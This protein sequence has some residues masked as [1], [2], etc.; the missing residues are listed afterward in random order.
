MAEL[1]KAKLE[2][3]IYG[4]DFNNIPAYSRIYID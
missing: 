1:T 3:Y 4:G 2:L